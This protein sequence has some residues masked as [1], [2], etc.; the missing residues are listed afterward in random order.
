MV[1]PHPLEVPLPEKGQ[2]APSSLGVFL[3]IC[4][5][6]RRQNDIDHVTCWSLGTGREPGLCREA[7]NSFPSALK[8]RGQPESWRVHLQCSTCCGQMRKPVVASGHGLRLAKASPRGGLPGTLNTAWSLRSVLF[9]RQIKEGEAARQTD[10]PSTR[11][12]PRWPQQ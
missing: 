6:L 4:L 12:L 8:L 3:K 10:L 11:S 7:A 5:F 9:E 2:A 1:K